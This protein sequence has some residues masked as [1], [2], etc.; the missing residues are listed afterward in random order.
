[1]T[2]R[3]SFDDTT[4]KLDAVATTLL[5]HPP[6]AHRSHADRPDNNT[7]APTKRRFETGATVADCMD[8]VIP[9]ATIISGTADVWAGDRWLGILSPG[10]TLHTSAHPNYRS[11]LRLTARSTLVVRIAP[12][13]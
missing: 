6:H 3:P 5:R 9:N 1:M 4:T 11:Q 8:D 7:M 10:D 13:G 2:H 12:D